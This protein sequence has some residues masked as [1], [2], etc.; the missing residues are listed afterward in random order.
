MSKLQAKSMIRRLLLGLLV[1]I[2]VSSCVS[3]SK[4]T[5]L[6]DKGTEVPDTAG[7]QEIIRNSYRIQQ[8]DILT[9]NIRSLDPEVSQ[10][11][12][13]TNVQNN[14]LNGGD[15]QFYLNGYSVDSEGFIE[16][17]VL[18]QI[19]VQGLTIEETKELVQQKLLYYFQEDAVFASVQL[20]GIRFSVVGE[21]T[22]PGKYV[23]YQNQANVFEALASAGDI[24]FVGDR[25]MVQIIRQY[26]EGVKT[27]DIDLTDKAILSNP[28]YMLQPN[29]IINVKPLS[30][31]SWGIGT[32][33]FDTFASILSILASSIL[34]VVNVQALSNN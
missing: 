19:Q 24:A 14:N 25:R 2:S 15:L 9:I 31:K 27:F 18:G 34:I 16:P 6:Q 33:G 3:K 32:T 23:I 17:P 10:M 26:P 1:A 20:A 21:V 28:T 30:A 29:D 4:L 5:Y 13:S 7:Y 12:N 11:F 22:R 8:N